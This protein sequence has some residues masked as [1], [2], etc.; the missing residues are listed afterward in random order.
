MALGKGMAPFHE[1]AELKKNSACKDVNVTNKNLKA[2]PPNRQL[3]L[4]LNNSF[5]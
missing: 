3:G 4:P 5:L 1:M 2:G